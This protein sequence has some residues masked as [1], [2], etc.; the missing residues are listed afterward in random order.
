MIKTNIYILMASGRLNYNLKMKHDVY[1]INKLF[2]MYVLY[3][4]WV[5]LVILYILNGITDSR[6]VIHHTYLFSYLNVNI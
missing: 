1:K 3:Y 5:Y 6:Y 2:I 4:H